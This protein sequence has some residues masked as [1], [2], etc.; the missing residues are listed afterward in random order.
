MHANDHGRPTPAKKS[1]QSPQLVL[2]GRLADLTAAGSAR[3]V[4]EPIT[5]QGH[6][7]GL[8]SRA[9]AGF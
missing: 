2:F 1:Y 8:F 5:A 6:G 3:T 9:R 7:D 4:Q